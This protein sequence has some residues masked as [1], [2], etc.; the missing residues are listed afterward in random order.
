[1]DY[2]GNEFKALVFEYMLN[3]SLEKWLHFVTNRENQSTY[4]N[5]IQRLNIAIDVAS[6]VYYLHEDSDQPVIHCDLK[7]SNVLLDHQMIAHVSDFGLA[8][9][10]S[11]TKGF[12]E[13]RSS[14]IGIKGTIGYAPPGSY[15]YL[16]L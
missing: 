6:A 13:S 14:T 12:S 9:L 11:Y 8:R 15:Y 2:N 1:M 4:L 3:G 10:I 7:P 5:L 16:F